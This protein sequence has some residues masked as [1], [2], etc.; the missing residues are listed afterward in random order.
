MSATCGS[1]AGIYIQSRYRLHCFLECTEAISV[2]STT[3]VILSAIYSNI[4]HLIDS[5]SSI[6]VVILRIYSCA[7]VSHSDLRDIRQ[8]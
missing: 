2:S 3:T 8:V 5:P 6:L 4:P 1:I 7:E